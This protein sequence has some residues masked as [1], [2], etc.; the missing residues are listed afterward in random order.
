MK[1]LSLS[2]QQ[3]VQQLVQRWATFLALVVAVEAGSAPRW[4]AGP[5]PDALRRLRA[6]PGTAAALQ[7]QLD[8]WSK[9]DRSTDHSFPCY[10]TCPV[11]QTSLRASASLHHLRSYRYTVSTSGSAIHTC[12]AEPRAHSTLPLTPSLFAL[13]LSSHM[14]LY[15]PLSSRTYGTKSYWCIL[16]CLS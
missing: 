14:L 11:V 1:L 3:F 2:L 15:S 13:I 4:A 8:S 9:H 12:A 7:Q 5:P 16:H 6:T 10:R